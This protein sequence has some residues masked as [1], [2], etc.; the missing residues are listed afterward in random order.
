MDEYRRDGRWQVTRTGS[1]LRQ[2]PGSPADRL[3]L[4]SHQQEE[5]EHNFE[6]ERGS[7]AGRKR[8]FQEVQEPAQGGGARNYVQRYAQQH[9]RK[10]QPLQEEGGGPQSL[11]QQEQQWQQPL[12]GRQGQRQSAGMPSQA[13]LYAPLSWARQH[14]SSRGHLITRLSHNIVDTV[15]ALT[16]SAADLAERQAMLGL[17]DRVC[18][19]ALRDYPGLQVL[20]F[21]SY[22]SG[23]GTCV[24]DLDVVL[25]NVK[26]PRN[27]SQGFYE[28]GERHAVA[29]LLD[30]VCRGLRSESSSI[31]I[32]NLFVI[33]FSRI[34]L[35]K[36]T[37]SL[38]SL[39][40]SS[41]Q[42]MAVDISIA[43]QSGP[44]AAAYLAKQVAAN[45]ALRPLVLVLKAYLKVK[46]L[47]EVASGGLSSYGLTYMVLAHLMEEGR[48]G[49]DVEDLGLMLLSVTA[50]SIAVS[51]CKVCCCQAR[52]HPS[53]LTRMR[54][55]ARSFFRRYGCAY[56][57]HSQVVSVKDGGI[58]GRNLA[59]HY[60]NM[61]RIC[62]LDPLTGRDCT[63][64]TYRSDEVLAALRSAHYGLE[65]LLAKYPKDCPS[66]L[67]I[68]GGLINGGWGGEAT[69]EQYTR[70]LP[71]DD[72]YVA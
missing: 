16:P 19:A 29:A 67:D 23:L 4:R 33:R 38:T 72:D 57:T 18:R 24:S 3:P 5:S 37:A 32:H 36:L 66:D 52:H 17:V 61:D 11:P 59:S 42:P 55:T 53:Q 28:K 51:H 39:D 2:Y 60:R 31:T 45:R 64:G 62:C 15:E 54:F 47:N 9:P 8:R 14:S 68:L 25:V 22:V 1:G 56:D 70:L 41:S 7:L 44:E 63:E 20:P 48:Q 65:E 35:A 27:A 50:L 13:V 58:V 10:G 30:R 43:T 71:A 12:G 46:E 21:G 40:T 6:T 49:R 69:D 34:P 26:H